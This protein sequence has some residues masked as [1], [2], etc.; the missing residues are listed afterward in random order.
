MS[1]NVVQCYDDG[2]QT[3]VNAITYPWITDNK[4]DQPR[5]SFSSDVAL[6]S[7]NVYPSRIFPMG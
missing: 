2:I 1:R 4:D 6:I 5:K 3:L 7:S